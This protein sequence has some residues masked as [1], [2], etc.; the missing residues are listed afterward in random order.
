VE[1]S[2][3]APKDVVLITL[4]LNDQSGLWR[5]TRDRC[6][7][8]SKN[9]SSLSAYHRKAA[10]EMLDQADRGD[11]FWHVR[12]EYLAA[13]AEVSQLCTKPSPDEIRQV[14][15]DLHAGAAECGVGAEPWVRQAGD[16][17]QRLA[18]MYS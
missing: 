16:L 8:I 2:I 12:A 9:L 10:Q 13:L 18:Q 17:L 1:T 14:L 11:R 4:M 5:V 15:I 7:V 3:T 6:R